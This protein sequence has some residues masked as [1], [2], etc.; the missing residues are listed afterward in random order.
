MQ[1]IVRGFHVVVSLVMETRL[2][3]IQLHCVQ[4]NKN[5]TVLG[6]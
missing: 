2:I 4:V 1:V 6:Q 3:Q 5:S